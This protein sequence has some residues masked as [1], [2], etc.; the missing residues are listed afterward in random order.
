Y[1]TIADGLRVCS[2]GVLP[3]E[4]IRAYVDGAVTVTDGEIRAAMRLL[5]TGGRL[6]AEPSGA[7]ATAAQMV[8]AHALPPRRPGA[9]GTPAPARPPGVQTARCP[10]PP[11]PCR[12]HCRNAGT[13]PKLVRDNP[14]RPRPASRTPS[15]PRTPSGHR[16]TRS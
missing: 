16:R 9:G 14:D 3:W 15:E 4:H 2:P 10:P 13:N 11:P 5:A 7:V 12:T 6:V 8:H 1:R